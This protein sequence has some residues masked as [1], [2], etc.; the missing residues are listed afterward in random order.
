MI[1]LVPFVPELFEWVIA[2]TGLWGWGYVKGRR[3]RRF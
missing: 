1:A 3:K 2:G